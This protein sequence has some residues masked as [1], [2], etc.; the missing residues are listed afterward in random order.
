[1]MNLCC[2]IV[3]A[4]NGK[5]LA[6]AESCTGGAIGAAITSVPGSSSVYRGGVVSYCNDIKNQMLGVSLEILEE[7]GAVSA[8]VAEAMA[9]GAKKA[10]GANIAVSVTGLAGPGGDERGNPV[11][12]VYIGYADEQQV[13]HQKCF[14]EGGRDSVREQAVKAALMLVYE[15]AQSI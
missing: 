10:L 6:T 7:Y 8:P 15:N 2:D 9:V 3:K 13:T 11:G 14:F 12:L 4:L 1:M 5:T